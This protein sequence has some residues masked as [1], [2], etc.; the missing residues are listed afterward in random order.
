MCESSARSPWRHRPP[1]LGHNLD[2]PRGHVVAVLQ[3]ELQVDFLSI[4][5]SVLEDHPADEKRVRRSR[6][7][8]GDRQTFETE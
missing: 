1:E 2:V 8:E 7:D 6:D 5:E 4:D 3:R